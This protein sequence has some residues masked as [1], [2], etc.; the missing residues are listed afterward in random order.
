VAEAVVRG[1]LIGVREDLVGLV[2][3]LELFR[4]A[5]VFITVGVVLEGQ[6]AEGLS[7]IFRRGVTGHAENFIIIAFHCHQ[8]SLL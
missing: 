8:L 4:G 3:L 1:T 6:P 5:V 7:D 2:D